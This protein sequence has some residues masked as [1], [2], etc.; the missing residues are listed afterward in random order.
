M[1]IGRRAP[2]S[3]ASERVVEINRPATVA[4]AARRAEP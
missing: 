3:Q 1:P 2:G 4:M